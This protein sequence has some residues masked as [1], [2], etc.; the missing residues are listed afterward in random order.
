MARAGAAF[1]VA[2]SVVF[3]GAG[4]APVDRLARGESGRVDEA[5]DGDTVTLDGGLEVRLVGLQA[6]KLALGRPGFVDW[7]LAGRA[8]DALAR[9]VGGRAV[10]LRHGGARRDRHGR[11]LAHL[12]RGDGLWVQGAMLAA[13]MARVYSFADNRALVREMLA[14]ER[15]ARAARRGIWA[16]PRYRVRR[17]D[18]LDGAVD[19]FQLVEGEVVSAAVAR[20]RLF[21]N[22]GADWGTDFTITAAPRDRPA[23]EAAWAAAGIDPVSALAGHRVRVRGWIGRY[24]GPRIVATHPEQIELPDAPAGPGQGAEAMIYRGFATA[25]EIDRE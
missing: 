25:E 6:P 23:F 15:E 8:R 10:V 19:T 14:I 12:V 3:A 7:P 4:A 9:L 11:A 24:D 18:A 22:F 16:H 5:V 17:A 21:V 2:V 1:A 20:G 13:G